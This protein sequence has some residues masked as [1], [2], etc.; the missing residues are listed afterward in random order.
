M[1][2]FTARVTR[3]R[4]IAGLAV[5]LLLCGTAVTVSSLYSD[6]D[7]DVSA[8]VPVQKKVKTN[9]DRIAYLEGLGWKVVS[10]PIA[11]EELLIPEKFDETYTEYLTLQQKQGFDLT[12]YCGKRVK[13]CTYE[14]TN[15]PTGEGGVQA[16]LLIYKSHPNGQQVPRRR[17]LG[18]CK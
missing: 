12:Q 5:F 8:A 2:I 14:I 4:L 10:E 16:S 15:Y 1:F 18:F 11:I 9:E 13:R 17:L 7:I 6:P 3:K